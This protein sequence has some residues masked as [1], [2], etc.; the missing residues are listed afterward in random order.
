MTTIIET[1]NLSKVFKDTIDTY[2]GADRGADFVAAFMSRIPSEQ[3]RE[4][5]RQALTRLVH[6]YDNE[7]RRSAMAAATKPLGGTETPVNTFI[8]P[9]SGKTFA[10]RKVQ[11]QVEVYWPAWMETRIITNNGSKALAYATVSDLGFYVASLRSHATQTMQNAEKYERLR[12]VMIEQGVSE[13][14][15]LDPSAYLG[16]DM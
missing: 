14:R 8:S 3:E 4:A 12:I 10:S 15:L 5:L 6:V 13:V 2:E 11:Q 7:Y 1:F 9:Q 16:L